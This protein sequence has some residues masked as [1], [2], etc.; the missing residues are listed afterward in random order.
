MSLGYDYPYPTRITNK[1]TSK[2]EV[3]LVDFNVHIIETTYFT[4][5]H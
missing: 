2:I 5:V 3:T 1:F 4:A